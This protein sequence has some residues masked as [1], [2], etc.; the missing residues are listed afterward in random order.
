M[1]IKLEDTNNCGA[2]ELFVGPRKRLAT[3]TSVKLLS[4][5]RLVACHLVGQRMYLIRFDLNSGHHEIECCIP[6][7]SNGK[8]VSTDL[9]D[10]DGKD[11]FVTS[12][13]GDG[14]VTIY[15]L[16]DGRLEHDKDIKIPVE[17]SAFCHGARFVPPDGA[18]ICATTTNNTPCAYF[19]STETGEIVY[20]LSDGEL[21]VKDVCFFGDGRMV[22]LYAK[23]APKRK[24]G[25]GYNS[26]L[27]LIA[28][29]LD[30]KLHEVL[31]QQMIA[32]HTD[33]CQHRRGR[34][35]VS[36]PST[37][38]VTVYRVEN[39]RLVYDRDVEGFDFPHGRDVLPDPDLLAV[40]NY[41][42][43]TIALRTL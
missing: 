41:A 11:R 29:D 8:D 16:T 40:T 13:C 10:F 27:S 34:V 31:D 43:N 12:N 42:S 17:R 35:Y 20:K 32:G 36:N 30:A 37:D 39:D 5:R 7:Q 18:M 25:T 22:A 6:T 21:K 15:R 9:L 14:S 33:C 38:S 23:V 19:I 4:H 1:L 28:I 2:T 26:R 3:C 24:A